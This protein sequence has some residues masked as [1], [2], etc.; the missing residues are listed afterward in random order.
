M[1]II[2]VEKTSN[3][4]RLNINLQTYSQKNTLGLLSILQ[5]TEQF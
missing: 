1:T 5:I 2:E 4:A 3:F